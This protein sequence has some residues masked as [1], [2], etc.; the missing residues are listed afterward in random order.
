MESVG[1]IMA[2]LVFLVLMFG[3]EVVA[4]LILVFSALF[5]RHLNVVILLGILAAIFM[6]VELFIWLAATVIGSSGGPLTSDNEG[7]WYLKILTVISILSLLIYFPAAILRWKASS[8]RNV[9][10]QDAA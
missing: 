1:N 4:I 3:L 8:K 5:P 6:F 2:S 9:A 10:A 7:F